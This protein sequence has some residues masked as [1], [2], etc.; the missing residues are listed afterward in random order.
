MY[1]FPTQYPRICRIN[2]MVRYVKNLSE[3]DA[4]L[5][6]MKVS[7]FTLEV[8]SFNR[9]EILKEIEKAVQKTIQKQI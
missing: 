9:T 8:K 5:S 2:I 4:S 7:K 1:L 6:K 3:M